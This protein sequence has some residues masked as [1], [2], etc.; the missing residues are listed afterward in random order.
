MNSHRF[1]LETYKSQSSRHRCPGCNKNKTFTLYIDTETNEPVNDR[2]GRCNREV[3]CAYHLTPSEYFKDNGIEIE[4]RTYV[5]PVPKPQPP[6]SYIDPA[7]FKRSLAA[8]ESNNFIKFLLTIFDDTTVT[9]LISK[10][11][12]GTSAHW[13]GATVFW[14]IDEQGRV[15]TG[16]V[17]LYNPSTGK[18]VSKP[19]RHIN[20]THAVLKLE[21]YN[22]KT[23]MF[24]GH[25]LKSEPTKPV[26][27]VESEKTAMIASVYMPQY[28]WV[29]VG[30]LSQLNA[31]KCKL[32]KGRTVMLYPDLNAYDKWEAKGNEFGFKTSNVLENRATEEEKKQ[33]LDIADYLLRVN[34]NQLTNKS[35]DLSDLDTENNINTASNISKPPTQDNEVAAVNV[36]PDVLKL[37]TDFE[38][39]DLSGSIMPEPATIEKIG[40]IA[41]LREFIGH[42]WQKVVNK[43][44]HKEYLFAIESLH[45]VREYYNIKAE[46]RKE[47]L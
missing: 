31:D 23:C 16:K 43:K 7:I 19:Y 26:A 32:L 24:G 37:R 18:R 5:P 17:M 41:D 35:A 1:T 34:I 39:L 4:H 12:I 11:F 3:E 45:L 22:L 25:L 38:Q 10:Y 42:L 21:N 28:V 44:N 40:F 46:R 2:V 30:G 47:T 13:P 8:Y 14:Q 27:I 6:T 20:W 29:A 9:R 33:G 15:R 36:H